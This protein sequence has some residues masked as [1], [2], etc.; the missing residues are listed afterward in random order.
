M[1]KYETVGRILKPF[2][3]DGTLI[4]LIDPDYSKDIKKVKSIFI[5]IKGQPVPFFIEK[6]DIE[7]E[8]VYIKFEE[9]NG[10]EDVK[11]FNSYEILLRDSDIK[12]SDKKKIPVFNYKDLLDF[13][14]IDKT[15][16]N[17]TRIKDLEQFPQQIMAI[18]FF[19]E[20]DVYLPLV[21]SFIEQIDIDKREIIMNLP[22][23]I[24]N[25]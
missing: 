20:S 11:P 14:I 8:L 1:L 5:K 2:K 21:E 13:L 12:K 24:F 3:Y 4:A 23:G 18:V 9:F 17:R 22:E 25:L 15:S 16:G 19:N 6:L 7:N 10:P